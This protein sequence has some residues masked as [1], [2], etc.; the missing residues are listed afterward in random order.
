VDAGEEPWG[1][2]GEGKTTDRE[3]V[4]A[5]KGC[6]GRERPEAERKTKSPSRQKDEIRRDKKQEY[7][8]WGGRDRRWGD[9][10]AINAGGVRCNTRSKMKLDAETLKRIKDVKEAHDALTRQTA[11]LLAHIA[12]VPDITNSPKLPRNR[13]LEQPQPV[14]YPWIR[15]K[16]RWRWD[17]ES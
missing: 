8:K 15:T 5:V 13:R 4:K 2:G 10:G 16:K 3:W 1:A 17:R 12:D 9:T 11:R 7:A 14:K 6:A